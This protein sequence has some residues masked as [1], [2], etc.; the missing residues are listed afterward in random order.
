MTKLGKTLS[1]EILLETTEH[2]ANSQ[3]PPSFENFEVLRREFFPAKKPLKFKS[4][5]HFSELSK[6]FIMAEEHPAV[7]LFREYLRIKSVHPNPDY[8][9]C[10]VFLKRMAEE[11]ELPWQIV[12]P[13]KDKPVRITINLK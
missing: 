1:T 13:V 4:F 10:N 2:F 9:S 7:T 11:L 5:F 3:K 6:S 8:E 12:E